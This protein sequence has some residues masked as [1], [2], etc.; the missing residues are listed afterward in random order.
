[1]YDTRDFIEEKKRGN[2]VE[3]YKIF[4]DCAMYHLYIDVEFEGTFC[5]N[6]KVWIRV[7]VHLDRVV[8]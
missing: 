3:R 8:Y 7:K 2:F 4:P 5:Y 6:I 1:L